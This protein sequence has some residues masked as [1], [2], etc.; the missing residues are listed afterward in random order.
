MRKIWKFLEELLC[1][2]YPEYHGLFT[3]GCFLWF[4]GVFKFLKNHISSSQAS[5]QSMKD[6]LI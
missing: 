3:F 5:L 1:R 4:N 6:F 2:E